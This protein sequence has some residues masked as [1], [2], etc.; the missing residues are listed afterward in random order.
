MIIDTIKNYR[1]A[2]GFLGGLALSSDAATVDP[3]AAV[4]D[5]APPAPV[6]GIVCKQSVYRNWMTLGIGNGLIELQV[7]PEI[8][9]RIIQLKL[10]KK[11]FLWVNPQLAGRLPPPTGLAADGGWFNV[12]GDKLW[13]APQGWD[14]DRQWPGPPDAVLDGQPYAL[15]VLPDR[16]GQSAIRLTSRKDPRSGIKFSRV[17]RIFEGSTRVGFSATMQNIDDKPRRW[18]I[19]SH[20]QLE[21]SKADRAGHNQLLKAWCPINPQSGFPKGYNLM[22]GEEDNPSFEPHAGPGLMR[23]TYQYKLGKIGLDSHAGWVATV[24]GECGAVFVQRFVFQ[25]KMEYPDGS[26]VEFWL[27]GTGHIHAFNKE[28]I[29]RDNPVENPHVFES[30]LLSPYASLDPGQSYTWNYDWYAGSIGG[31]FPVLDCSDAGVVVEP[32]VATILGESL[33][34]RGKFGVFIQGNLEA[35]AYDRAGRELAMEKLRMT[36]TPLQP[37]KVD[38]IVKLPTEAVAVALWIVDAGGSRRGELSRAYV[39]RSPF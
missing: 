12:G 31:D 26:S 22:F 9:G 17:V 14:N 1:L 6:P 28:I 19:W 5:S 34:I 33:G 10:G 16:E 39:E 20:T 24:D 15:E 8:G 4:H 38:A 25:P 27:N 36:V 32:L 29:M 7:L 35:V 13:P 3:A 30:E 23:V 2:R 37:A 18:G 21:G 11:E